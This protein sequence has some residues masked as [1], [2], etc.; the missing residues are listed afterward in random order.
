VLGVVIEGV[1]AGD[2][3]DN[4]SG[5]FVQP[6]GDLRFLLAKDPAVGLG[7][8]PAECI[9]QKARRIQHGHLLLDGGHRMHRKMPAHP[10]GHQ[11]MLLVPGQR[12]QFSPEIEAPA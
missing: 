4:Q 12:P 8:V 5:R 11:F 10:V 2:A 1:A 7:Q 6:C 9:R 3:L